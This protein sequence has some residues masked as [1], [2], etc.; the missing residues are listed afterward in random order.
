MRGWSVFLIG[1][2]AGCG[3]FVCTEIGCDDGLVVQLDPAPVGAF[4]VEAQ[5]EGQSSPA[6]FNCPE[7]SRCPSAFFP[8]LVTDQVTVRVTT[9]AGTATQQFRPQ[10]EKQYPNGRACG[11]ACRQATVTVRLPG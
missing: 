9:A 4:R 5:A 6:V 11:A 10:Y 2:L 7:G 3:P 8:G 1:L